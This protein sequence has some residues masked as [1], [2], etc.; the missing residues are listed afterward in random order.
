MQRQ[1]EALTIAF[2]FALLSMVIYQRQ[3]MLE[4]SWRSNPGTLMAESN[5]QVLTEDILCCLLTNRMLIDFPSPL[6]DVA[7]E[8][9]SYH[10]VNR[11]IR[12]REGGT[13]LEPMQ[14]RTRDLFASSHPWQLPAP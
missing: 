2:S 13:N 1:L 12:T 3:V 6:D 8:A 14:G 9:Y 10:G 7:T 5:T 11:F 4:R